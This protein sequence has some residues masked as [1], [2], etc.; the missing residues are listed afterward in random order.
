MRVFEDREFRS[1]YDQ[2]LLPWSRGKVF[3]D[4]EF[5]R[6]YFQSCALSITRNPRARSL[7]RNVRLVDCIAGAAAKLYTP[8]I[9]NV[10]V[11][12]LKTEELLPAWGAVFRHLTIRGRIG[13]LMLNSAIAVGTAK[14]EEQRAF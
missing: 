5:H 7:V 4:L 3:E 14:R 10:L 13:R 1:L 8:I 2:P 11:D 9:D 12:G 6:C